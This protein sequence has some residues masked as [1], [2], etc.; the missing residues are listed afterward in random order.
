MSERKTEIKS[1]IFM[2]ENDADPEVYDH[3]LMR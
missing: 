3:T 2:V 1:W